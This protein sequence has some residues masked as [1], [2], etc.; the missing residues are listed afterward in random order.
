MRVA[1]NETID[2]AERLNRLLEAA[3]LNASNE[4]WFDNENADSIRERFASYIA[5]TMYEQTVLPHVAYAAWS[6]DMVDPEGKQ[7]FHDWLIKLVSHALSVVEDST[8][9][10]YTADPARHA[11]VSERVAATK[12]V[13]GSW[14][15]APVSRP[16]PQITGED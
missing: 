8:W 7:K 4:D 2:W 12:G 1:I 14:C 16:V 3:Y 9:Y 11:I 13:R 6:F 10:T 15:Y 5:E